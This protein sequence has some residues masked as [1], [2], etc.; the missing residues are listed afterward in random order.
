MSDEDALHF[1][2]A[3][4]N[5][6]NYTSVKHGRWHM[7]TTSLLLQVVETLQDDAFTTGEPIAHIG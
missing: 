1:L 6:L 3:H 5:M 7:P 2:D 4:V